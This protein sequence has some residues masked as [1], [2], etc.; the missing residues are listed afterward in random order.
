VDSAAFSSLT[1][2]SAREWTLTGI[3]FVRKQKVPVVLVVQSAW[4]RT[5]LPKEKAGAV[6]AKRLLHPFRKGLASMMAHAEELRDLPMVWN[7]PVAGK[8]LI[9]LIAFSQPSVRTSSITKMEFE[10]SVETEAGVEA[11]ASQMVQMRNRLVQALMQM[12]ALAAKSVS[13]QLAP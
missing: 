5:A 6:T 11:T 12:L 10:V 1:T 4:R 7:V 9:H 8:K 3:L 2:E 13:T